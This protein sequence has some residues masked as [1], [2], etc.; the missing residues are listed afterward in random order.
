MKYK[1]DCGCEFDVIEFPDGEKGVKFNPDFEIMNLECQRTWNLISSGDTKGVFQLE[2]Q[3]QMAKKVKPNSIEELSDLISIL[4]PGCT[5]SFLEDGKSL[6][7]HYNERKHGREMPTY[8]HPDLK[9]IIGST[10]GILVY[11]EQ[12]MQIASHYAG[13]TLQEADTLRKAIGKK[14]PEIMAKMKTLFLEK[15]EKKGIITKAEA[16]EIFSWIE[17]SQR[18]SFNKCLLGDTKV[19]VEDINGDWKGEITKVLYDIKTG[20]RVK[21]PSDLHG[22]NEF[23]EVT[24]IHRNGYNDVFTVHLNGGYYINCTLNHQFLCEDG[25][26]KTVKNIFNKKCKI[27]CDDGLFHGIRSVEYLGR[28]ETMDIEVDSDL[29]VFYGN[30]ISTSNSHGISYAFNGYLTAFVKAHFTK[31]FFSSWLKQ[32]KDK[33]DPKLEIAQLVNNA[34]T[35]FITVHPPMFTYPILYPNF[36]IVGKKIHFGF[37]DVKDIGRNV[38]SKIQ[39]K[40][41]QVKSILGKNH[42]DWTWLEFLTYFAIDIPSQAMRAMIYSG[43]IDHFNIA[44]AKMVYEYKQYCELTEREREWCKKEVLALPQDSTL[45][46]ILEK[47][48]ASGSGKNKGTATSKRL[49]FVENL[50]SVLQNPPYNLIDT[51][52]LIATIEEG[53]LGIPLTCSIVDG[54]AE[55]E[56]A[57]CSCL[58]FIHNKDLRLYLLA[59]KIDRIKETTIKNGD[60]RGQ[61]MAFLTVSDASCSLENVVTFAESYREYYPLLQVGNTVIVSGEKGK[62]GA[63]IVKKV[64][65]I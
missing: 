59:V 15:A 22:H 41:E 53:Y 31:A 39:E 40:V 56:S 50:L 42:P 26:K 58:E 18:Y 23:V 21:A 4:R 45:S 32:S 24:N 25:T 1:F 36:K 61:K 11:Q 16:E 49:K 6:T 54:R 48:I 57:N 10:Y 9:N 20:D 8:L 52:E 37:L 64:F 3:P 34:K 19:I 33:Q 51:P 65:Q 63:L 46:T 30:G 7:Y 43:C 5:E 28:K 17:A 62:D 2:N 55:K 38:F 60:S 12:A 27:L 13:F 44:R 29:H 35:K 14:K 47:V